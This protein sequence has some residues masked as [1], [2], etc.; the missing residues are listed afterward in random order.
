MYVHVQDTN[1]NKAVEVVLKS[2]GNSLPYIKTISGRKWSK[3]I[4]EQWDYWSWNSTFVRISRH[5]SENKQFCLSHKS[6]VCN[7]KKWPV[8]QSST[9]QFQL[10]VHYIVQ[11]YI[12]RFYD[13]QSTW[14]Q[15]DCIIENVKMLSSF[16]FLRANRGIWTDIFPLA[17]PTGDAYDFCEKW[18]YRETQLSPLPAAEIQPCPCTLDQARLD[19]VRFQPDPDCNI[20]GQTSLFS[21]TGN[22][23]Y[24]KDAS[25]CIRLVSIK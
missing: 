6:D 16:W 9:N 21:R 8:S 7:P 25:H 15:I 11:I 10:H 14:N 20:F 23:L 4:M 3:I 24:R 1:S 5:F 12:Q 19:I 13:I 2:P 18:L 17:L 22:C